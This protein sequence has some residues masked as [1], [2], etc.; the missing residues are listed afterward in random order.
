M[1][2][3]IPQEYFP[4]DY[5]NKVYEVLKNTWSKEE[6]I[7]MFNQGTIGEQLDHERQIPAED[8]VE[9]CE[10]LNFADLSRRAKRAVEVN[11]LFGIWCNAYSQFR[12]EKYPR[13]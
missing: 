13:I 12:I 3:R 6:V 5:F 10:S 9:A 2:I 7:N 4:D 8:I 11:K 1:R